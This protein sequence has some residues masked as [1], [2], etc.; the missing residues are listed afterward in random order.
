M[1]A[2]A[3]MESS[4][5][6]PRTIR[7][8]SAW[9]DNDGAKIYTISAD[10]SEVD[11]NAFSPRLQAIK[12]SRSVKWGETAHFAI[13]HGG[14]SMLYLILCWWG[15]DNELFTAVSVLTPDGWV[16]QPDRYSFCL[17]DLE[18]FWD[19]R[20]HYIETIDCAQPSMS[21]YRERLRAEWSTPA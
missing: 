10:G 20:N 21:R 3:D 16:E 13:F 11:R 14:A 17:Y 19:E 1:K 15:N 6:R 8:S 5:Y 9:R 2:F 7:A 12:A 18:V 4:M